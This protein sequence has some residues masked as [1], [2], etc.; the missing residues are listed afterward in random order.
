[1]TS[2]TTF[3]VAAAI[4]CFSA[5][6]GFAV[7]G[8]DESAPPPQVTDCEQAEAILREEGIEF[9]HFSRCPTVEEASKFVDDHRERRAEAKALEEHVA[10]LKAKGELP[11]ESSVPTVG[12]GEDAR[13]ATPQEIA[14]SLGED[15][16]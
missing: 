12:V 14:A 13:P 6:I 4:A 3:L 1:M 5:S 7:A 10:Q 11:E 16:K 8:S 2:R 15:S 9:D